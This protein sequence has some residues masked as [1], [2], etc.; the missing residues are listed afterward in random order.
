MTASVAKTVEA[1][2]AKTV[3]AFAESQPKRF[4]VSMN[5]PAFD[6][7]PRTTTAT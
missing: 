4:R 3:E 5:R 1:F 2:V 6:R 7:A